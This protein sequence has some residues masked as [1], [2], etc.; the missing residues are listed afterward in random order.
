MNGW[1]NSSGK[2]RW[3]I[4]TCHDTTHSQLGIPRMQVFCHPTVIMPCIQI[5]EINRS[6]R[7]PQGNVD[8]RISMKHRLCPVHK[9]GHPPLGFFKDFL[10]GGVVHVRGVVVV[11][12][13]VLPHVHQVVD[14]GV[15]PEGQ[16]TFDELRMMG[17]EWTRLGEGGRRWRRTVESEELRGRWEERMM[18]MR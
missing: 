2:G 6:V 12:G 8:R 3:G 16:G 7:K 18:N 4:L 14:L 1:G 5:D 17:K 10:L 9:L 15:A 11:G 13:L